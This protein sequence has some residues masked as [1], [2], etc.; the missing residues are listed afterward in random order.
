MDHLEE[1]QSLLQKAAGEVLAVDFFMT[2]LRRVVIF[3]IGVAIVVVLAFKAANAQTV[4]A[5]AA[6]TRLADAAQPQATIITAARACAAP[7]S[8]EERKFCLE[9][10][11]LE[12]SRAKVAAKATAKAA[13]P[14][15][16]GWMG[17]AAPY[18]YGYSGGGYYGGGYNGYYPVQGGVR[19]T[20]CGEGGCNTVFQTGR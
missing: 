8:K 18:G 3:L 11:K 16:C 19:T 5:Q 17:C 14:A 9:L 1:N 13:K 10:A 2:W 20:G 6:A 7:S 12:V 15:D 4:P